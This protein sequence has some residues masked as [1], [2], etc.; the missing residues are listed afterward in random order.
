M[1]LSVEEKQNM[2][3]QGD[4]R[5]PDVFETHSMELSLA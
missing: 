5:E 1:F 2:Y 3:V 4:N